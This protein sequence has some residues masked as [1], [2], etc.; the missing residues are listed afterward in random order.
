MDKLSIQYTF[1]ISQLQNLKCIK[2]KNEASIYHFF[3]IMSRV[4]GLYKLA[5]YHHTINIK[6]ATETTQG[7][8]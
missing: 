6:T 4:Y 2:Q 5:N 8:I 3:K 7:A 1:P